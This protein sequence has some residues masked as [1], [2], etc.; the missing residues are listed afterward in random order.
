MS[1]AADYVTAGCFS[2]N[3]VGETFLPN[4]SR[5]VEIRHGWYDL[6]RCRSDFKTAP[7]EQELPLGSAAGLKSWTS[8]PD[9]IDFHFWT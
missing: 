6:C 3:S 7:Q 1:V 4:G 8:C 2:Q 5:R 9:T